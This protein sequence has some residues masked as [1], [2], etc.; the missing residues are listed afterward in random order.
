MKR[1]A[2]AVVLAGISAAAVSGAKAETIVVYSAGPKPLSGALAKAFEK[3]TG[4]R[5]DLFQSTSGKVMA[6]Y[7]AEKSNPHADVLISASWGHAITLA[8]KGDLLA[9]TSPNAAKVPASL[10]TPTYVAQGAAALSIVY[11]TT[12]GVTPPKAW[13]DLAKPEYKD[14]VTMPDPAKSGSALTLVEGLDAR[15]KDGAWAL[16]RKLKANGMIIPGANN[17][18][19]DPVLQGARSVVFGAVDYIALGLRKK[20]EKI[21][22]VYPS[23]GTVL[24]PRPI[25]IPKSTRHAAAAKKFVDFVLSREGQ[26]LVAKRFI[27]PART[28]V[29]ALRAGWNDL[30]II[31]FDLAAAARH[32]VATKKKFAAAVR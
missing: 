10:K 29:K 2:I 25:M 21:A 9:Y 26:E 13:S 5:V 11:N 31:D 12:S 14:L 28:D 30:N 1:L 32:A 8:G 15:M 7:Q 4:I 24:A 6:R 23:D 22:V 16:F 18:A 20:G 27:L 3:Q 17:A 19:L